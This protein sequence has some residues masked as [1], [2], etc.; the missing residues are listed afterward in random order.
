MA[1]KNNA[2]TGKADTSKES[3]INHNNILP[4]ESKLIDDEDDTLIDVS[5]LNA[6]TPDEVE[7]SQKWRKDGK[8]KGLYKL[9]SRSRRWIALCYPETYYSI[10][11][12]TDDKV[13]LDHLV[14]RCEG[15]G[16]EFAISPL[17]DSDIN[18]D[19]SH[20][21]DHWHLI[22]NFN[23]ST[24]FKVASEH[25]R[26]ATLGP[27]PLK[28]LS[29]RHAYRYFTHAD[30]PEKAQY[31]RDEIITGNGFRMP[32]DPSEKV[33]ILECLRYE[34]I[35]DDIQSF[36]ELV[37]MYSDDSDYSDTIT[38]YHVYLRNFIRDY[39]Y[40]IN[41]VCRAYARIG[42]EHGMPKEERDRL[43]ESIP[44]RI[45]KQHDK[46]VSAK[47]EEMEV[48]R[49]AREIYRQKHEFKKE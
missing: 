32:L 8:Y 45:A 29:I 16:V 25:I 20:K 47:L 43:I 49:E 1:K 18:A 5:E 19:G 21:K 2:S 28:C 40:N 11:N 37:M 35:R 42:A 14:K 4:D 23:G 36:A 7:E 24:T 30:N 38:S 15:T 46:S 34:I 3:I 41:T 31:C 17:H 6:I 22:Y 33:E 26:A 39:T 13:V 44:D 12:T 48:E 27:Y 9:N 10:L